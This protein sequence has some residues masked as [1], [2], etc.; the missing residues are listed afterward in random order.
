MPPLLC[1]AI[2]R[3]ALAIMWRKKRPSYLCAASSTSPPMLLPEARRRSTLGFGAPDHTHARLH[4]TCISSCA[5]ANTACRCRR[6]GNLEASWSHVRPRREASLWSHVLLHLSQYSGSHA[7]DGYSSCV[8]L[9]P[10]HPFRAPFELQD[11]QRRF[12]H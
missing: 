2:C 12:L 10:L 11:C 7:L 3:H 5:T 4:L 1:F 6:T 9:S 8:Y